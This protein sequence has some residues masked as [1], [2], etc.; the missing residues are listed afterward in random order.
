M[1]RGATAVGAA[2]PAWTMR[3]VLVAVGRGV[4][5]CVLALLLVRGI[6]DVLAGDRTGESVRPVARPAAAWPD[7]GARAFAVDFAAAYLSYA[8]GDQDGYVSRLRRFVSADVA[9]S[10][11][12]RFAVQTQQSVSNATVARTVSVD[13]AHALVTVAARMSGRSVSAYLTVPVARDDVGGLTVYDLPSFSAAPVHGKVDPVEPE[14]LASGEQPAIEDVLRRFLR[15]YMAGR[16]AELEYF[17]PAGTRM[18]ALAQPLELVGLDSVSQDGAAHGRERT[19]LATVRARDRRTRAV[20]ALRYRLR[21]VRADRW[22]VAAVN[23]S[24]KEG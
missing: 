17:V 8:P 23:T 2:L 10:A 5:W 7:D 18:A 14:Q 21:L 16:D 22:Y 9:E 20:Y 24:P 13:K 4:L 11:L 1:S 12:P 6:S 3:S 15:A 19:V